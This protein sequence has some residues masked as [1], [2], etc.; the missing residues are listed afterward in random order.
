MTPH[1]LTRQQVLISLDSLTT[2]I[3]MANATSVVKSCNKSLVNTYSKLRIKSV[4]K[5]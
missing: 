4:Y 3:I 1:R 5:V 2:E